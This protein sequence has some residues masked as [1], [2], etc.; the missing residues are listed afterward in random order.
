MKQNY[1]NVTLGN[2]RRFCRKALGGKGE[3]PDLPDPVPQN[4]PKKWKN[5]PTKKLTFKGK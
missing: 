5:S 4:S 2:S 3:G 1:E